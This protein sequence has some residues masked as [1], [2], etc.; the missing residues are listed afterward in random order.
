[1]R[2]WF[3]RVTRRD[4]RLLCRWWN[5]HASGRY[6]ARKDSA[7]RFWIVVREEE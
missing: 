3:D 2:V 4:A 5:G 6:F 7:G 1:M